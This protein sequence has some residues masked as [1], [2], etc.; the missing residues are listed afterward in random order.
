VGVYSH[1]GQGSTFSLYLPVLPIER[2]QVLELERDTLPRGKGEAIL[3]VEDEPA[4]SEALVAGLTML[5]YRVKSVQNGHEALL[6]LEEH[7]GEVNLVLSDV[8]MPYMG[9][10]A[11][12]KA[13]RERLLNIP[14]LLITGHP[15]QAEMET[16][17]AE[18][19][20][21][22]ILKPPTLKQLAQSV[23]QAMVKIN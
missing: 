17:Q 10:I 16:L 23:S 5:N 6:Y 19:L 15:L 2:P 9:G 12:F 3:V 21:G 20:L 4:I 18:G 11:L 22:W 13:L 7:P 14:M 1:S 8:V